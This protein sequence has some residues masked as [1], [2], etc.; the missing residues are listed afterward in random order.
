MAKSKLARGI[1]DMVETGDKFV[2]LLKENVSK[3]IQ[4]AR[5]LKELEKE[6]KDALR[7]IKKKGTK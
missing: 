3:L 5:E 6:Y 1:I 2:A 7:K 4:A